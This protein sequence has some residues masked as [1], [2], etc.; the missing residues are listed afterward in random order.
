LQDTKDSFSS[1]LINVSV[2]FATILVLVILFEAY[3]WVRYEREHQRLVERYENVELCVRPAENSKLIYDFLPGARCGA[4]SLGFMD[5]ERSFD[6]PANT[7]RIVLIGD[8]VAQGQGVPRRS[9]FGNRLEMQLN[10]RSSETNYEVINLARTGYSTSQE[11][12]IFEDHGLRFKPDLVIWSYVLNDPAHPIFHDANGEMGR[13]FYRPAWRGLH[14]FQRKIFK[15]KEIAAQTR[16]GTEFH[17][18]LHCAYRDQVVEEIGQLGK[19]ADARSL[20]VVFLIHPLLEPGNDFSDYSAGDIHD[21]LRKI[22]TNAGLSVIDLLDSFAP[23]PPSSLALPSKFGGF[24]PWH[25]NERGHQL[26]ADYM[27]GKFS[28]MGI[29]SD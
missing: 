5:V 21:D 27:L 8:S 9:R 3:L 10:A 22:A 1:V 12:L 19:I 6:K 29:T 18:L 26:M 20:P 17:R 16:C 13:Y 14:Y 28:E 24:D 2:S 11:L 25:P 4:N 7:F 23:L 15:A